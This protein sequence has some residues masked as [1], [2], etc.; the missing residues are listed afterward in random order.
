M[1]KHK[2]EIAVD[3][4]EG[5]KFVAWLNKNGHDAAIGSSTGNY[6]DGEWTSSDDDANQ[7][8]NNLWDKYCNGSAARTLGSIK[9]PRKSASS[10]ENGKKGGRP[11]S[12]YIEIDTKGRFSLLVTPPKKEDHVIN[13]RQYGVLAKFDGFSPAMRPVWADARMCFLYDDETPTASQISTAW[14]VV[15]DVLKYSHDQEYQ[16]L[17]ALLK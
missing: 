16:E 8:L 11:K 17:T 15:A 14:G 12:R 6:V 13:Y 3:H 7:I 2:I 9:S 5:S 10:R 1:K 4:L